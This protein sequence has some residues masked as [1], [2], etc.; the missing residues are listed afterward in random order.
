MCLAHSHHLATKLVGHRCLCGK[1]TCKYSEKLI[2][3]QEPTPV[4]IQIIAIDSLLM[5]YGVPHD[6]FSHFYKIE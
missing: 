6:F 1:T 2:S 5:T 3:N 4:L